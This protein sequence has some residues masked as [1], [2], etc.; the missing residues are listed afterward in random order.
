MPNTTP[1]GETTP[2]SVEIDL[3]D[4]DLKTMAN[5]EGTA[6]GGVVKEL[7]ER[8][9]GQASASHKSYDKYSAHGTIAWR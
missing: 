5:L 8:T 1:P 7:R 9:P 3:S 6:L 2:D 4:L